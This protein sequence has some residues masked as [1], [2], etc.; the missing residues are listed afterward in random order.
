MRFLD[1]FKGKKVPTPV[2]EESYEEF[3]SRLLDDF[4]KNDH[5]G[6]AA[7]A[8][9]RP[10]S[11]SRI[12]TMTLLGAFTTSRKSNTF[13]MRGTIDSQKHSRWR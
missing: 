9:I 3:A 4:S 8:R 1:L 2:Q 6:K 10:G 7:I 5:L 13:N 12:K 11:Q